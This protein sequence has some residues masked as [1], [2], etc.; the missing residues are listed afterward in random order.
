M[1]EDVLSAIKVS[2]VPGNVGV[3]LLGSSLKE[4]QAVK[5]ARLGRDVAVFLDNDNEQVRANQRK[6]RKML[7]PLAKGEVSILEQDKD[8]KEFTT[9]ELREILDGISI[10]AD[11]VSIPE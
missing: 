1:T 6:A 2:R 8:P 4:P 11:T 5:A 7:E 10:D 9:E 3:A